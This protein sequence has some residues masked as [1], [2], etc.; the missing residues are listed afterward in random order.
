MEI[1]K[2]FQLFIS[3]NAHLLV[4]TPR[5]DVTQLAL[6]QS[7]DTVVFKQAQARALQSKSGFYI[8]WGLV[9]SILSKKGLGTTQ[10][11][12]GHRYYI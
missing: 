8:D 2:E 5:P 9:L 11:T 1:A 12:N 7:S 6:S 3:V 4:Q 10:N